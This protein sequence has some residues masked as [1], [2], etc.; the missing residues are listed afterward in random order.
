MNIIVGIIVINYILTIIIGI[1]RYQ[2]Q[3]KLTAKIGDMN[4]SLINQRQNLLNIVRYAE[5]IK[6][7]YFETLNKIKKELEKDKL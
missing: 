1:K 7:N 3:R 4:R 2:K 6:E 5:F